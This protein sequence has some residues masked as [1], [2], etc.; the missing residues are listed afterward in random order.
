M[1]CGAD[2]AAMLASLHKDQQGRPTR[3]IG[4]EVAFMAF[5][6]WILYLGKEKAKITLSILDLN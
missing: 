6:A 5:A 2:G 3:P 1:R 4:M